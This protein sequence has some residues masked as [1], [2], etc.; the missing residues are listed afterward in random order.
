MDIAASHRSFLGCSKIAQALDVSRFGTANELAAQYLGR[1]PWPELNSL[2]AQLGEPMEAVI[3]PF[4]EKE[5]GAVLRRDRREYHDHD[6]RMVAHLDYRALLLPDSP[7]ARWLLE[8]KR[9]VVD[10]KTSLS[11]AARERF[12]DE[13]DWDVLL[14]TQ[15]YTMLTGAPVA[16]VAAL[17]AGPALKV[18]EIPA[19]PELHAMIRAGVQRFWGHVTR[20]ELPP[21]RTLDDADLH[22]PASSGRVAHADTDLAAL[23]EEYRR[24]KSIL[25]DQR[26]IL[27]VLELRIKTAMQ[28]AEALS[29]AGKTLATWRNQTSARIDTTRLRAELPHVAEQYQK[30][31][32]SRVFR[33]KGE[34]A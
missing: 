16:F 23:I 15:G 13:V 11:F 33:L 5:I 9:P 14:Q 27:D 21:P 29:F 32:H 31:T 10:I 18:Y 26:E 8:S 17:V 2:A 25:N 24:T 12:G 28:D 6:L 20:G 3:K 19:D 4:A 34:K 22:W 30:Q 1:K 7:Y